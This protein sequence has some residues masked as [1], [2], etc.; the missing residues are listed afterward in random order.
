MLGELSA[1]SVQA[2]LCEPVDCEA[3]GDEHG[4]ALK[5]LQGCVA[6][7][8]SGVWALDQLQGLLD[9]IYPQDLVQQP[10]LLHIK[11]AI[12][13]RQSGRA[14]FDASTGLICP[15]TM[16]TRLPRHQHV[17]DVQ[18]FRLDL[19]N[20]NQTLPRLPKA[21]FLPSVNCTDSVHWLGETQA[22]L[23]P[24]TSLA[25]QEIQ[26]WPVILSRCDAAQPYADQLVARIRMS[27]CFPIFEQ[28][29]PQR[30]LVEH[31][32]VPTASHR[33]WAGFHNNYFDACQASWKGLYLNR[34][35]D[36]MV[37]RSSRVLLKPQEEA[38]SLPLRPVL[39]ALSESLERR[40][41]LIIEVGNRLS[42]QD[43]WLLSHAQTY[44]AFAGT[45]LEL[46]A[47]LGTDIS[48]RF[49]ML[50]GSELSVSEAQQLAVQHA[51]GY[52]INP[53]HYLR[54]DVML[55]MPFSHLR[56]IHLLEWILKQIEQALSHE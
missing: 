1:A 30:F 49:V 55:E 21:V 3:S 53:E 26:G 38:V 23:W 46:L 48:S 50:L 16:L 43:A 7:S 29:L 11:H 15:G 56:K 45:C 51:R 19:V 42:P 52:L 41:W 8:Q 39:G 54:S 22:Y 25:V 6:A 9:D 32:V 37:Q 34:H 24:F 35:H 12:V 14:L 17:P 47:V 20:S 28:D 40:G 36:Q 5:R 18:A 10:H 31:A 2:F 13:C 44:V 27:H 4:Q 33:V